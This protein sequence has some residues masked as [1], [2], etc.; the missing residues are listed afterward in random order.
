MRV[1]ATRCNNFV[2]SSNNVGTRADDHIRVY[3]IHN[4]RIA[5]FTDA[6]DYAVLDTDVSLEDTRPVDDECVRYDGVQTLLVWLP[7]CLSHAF[8]DSL[9]TS[10][11]ALVAIRRH[12]P[13]NFDP[14]VRCCQPDQIAGG[15]AKH[16]DVRLPLHGAHVDVCGVAPWLRLVQEAASLQPLHNALDNG[17]VFDEARC[18]AIAALDN[19]V[20]A[21][22]HQGNCL[23]IAGLEAHRGAGGNVEAVAMGS[24]AIELELRVRLDEVVVGAD[25]C[26]NKRSVGARTAET[27][28]TPVRACLQYS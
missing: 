10:K 6:N 27:A 4:I 5:C 22:L 28:C 11:G 7:A 23:G 12:V 26:S 21:N 8:S 17:R 15:W 24:Y 3:T 1:K 16:A 13:L 2:F 19:L 14:Q 18:N 20:A 25:L 9:S